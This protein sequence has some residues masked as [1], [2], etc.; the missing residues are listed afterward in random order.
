MPSQTAILPSSEM[1]ARLLL[2]GCHE[3][4]DTV[5]GVVRLHSA[6]RR[7][8]SHSTRSWS[9]PALTRYKPAHQASLS[10]VALVG[11][12]ELALK[13]VPDCAIGHTRG[14]V[15]DALCSVTGALI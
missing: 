3:T 13:E 4:A 2:L 7:P 5:L 8:T 14:Q 12:K 10:E 9:V 6:L 1:H 11:V 15:V